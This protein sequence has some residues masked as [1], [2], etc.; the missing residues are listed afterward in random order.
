MRDRY[1]ALDRLE[2]HTAEARDRLNHKL[3]CASRTPHLIVRY[4]AKL[5]RLENTYA[6]ER[7][8]I[9][10]HIR[11]IEHPPVRKPKPSRSG[12]KRGW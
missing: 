11:N 10:Q 5:A 7:A 8:R 1:L 9:D 3:D 4:K 12:N 2:R 6:L